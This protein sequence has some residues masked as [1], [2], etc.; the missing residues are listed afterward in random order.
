MT[1]NVINRITGV[2][3]A[4]PDQSNTGNKTNITVSLPSISDKTCL[5]INLGDGSPAIVYGTQ[6]TCPEIYKTITPRSLRNEI[7][8]SHRFLGSGS[9]QVTAIASD[10]FG[11]FTSEKLVVI[12]DAECFPPII[13]IRNVNSSFT[14]PIVAKRN[15]L[16]RFLTK[17]TIQCKHTLKNIKLW[18]IYP[19][20]PNSGEI[21]GEAII[22]ADNP[23]VNFAELAIKPG[24]LDTGLYKVVYQVKM[25]PSEFPSKE[26]FQTT[27]SEYLK[28]V[29]SDLI[30]MIENGGAS[31][32]LWGIN[33]TMI[34]S[35]IKYCYDPDVP[36]DGDQGFTNFIWYCKGYKQRFDSVVNDEMVGPPGEYST[37]GGCFGKGPGKIDFNSGNISFSTQWMKVNESY[38]FL[39]TAVKGE[40]RANG[41]LRV[42]IVEGVPGSAMIE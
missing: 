40:R 10:L 36:R 11:N 2:S 22:L 34:L 41:T 18:T 33:T 27:A 3:L 15:K 37:M 38:D 6:E 20:D 32:R 7:H 42:K 16:I 17:T 4:A 35:P 1:I 23:S 30:V 14:E 21:N 26:I 28:V 5:V 29:S 9:F 12:S 24:T 8:I 13:A 39:V 31:E 25:D 19:A